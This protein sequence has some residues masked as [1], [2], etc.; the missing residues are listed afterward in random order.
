MMLSHDIMRSASARTS[1]KG[2]QGDD[3]LFI[4][5]YSKEIADTHKMVSDSANC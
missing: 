5:G 4:P 2:E 3:G 1:C